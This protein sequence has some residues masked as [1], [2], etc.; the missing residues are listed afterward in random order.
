V[1]PSAPAVAVAPAQPCS[2]FSNCQHLT[3]PETTLPPLPPFDP[4]PRSAAP[5]RFSALLAFP[6][7]PLL[8]AAPFMTL[9]TNC[10]KFP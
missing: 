6:L 10:S 8:V 7:L 2:A 9:E 4:L 3:D 5:L 1:P